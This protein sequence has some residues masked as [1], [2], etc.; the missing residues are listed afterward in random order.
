MNQHLY[1]DPGYIQLLREHL[2][3][4]RKVLFEEEYASSPHP[5]K[6]STPLLLDSLRYLEKE[7][8]HLPQ[9][10]REAI[11]NVIKEVRDTLDRKHV[12]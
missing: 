9:I 7:K 12:P 3:V 6:R 4:I 1:R 11:D 10:Y 2:S 8:E 5:E